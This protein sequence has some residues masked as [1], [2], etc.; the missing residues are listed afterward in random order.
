MEVLFYFMIGALCSLLVL[1]AIFCIFVFVYFYYKL[2]LWAFE[3][4]GI[5]NICDIL[6]CFRRQKG[7]RENE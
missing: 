5:E 6:D 7:E 1:F 4:L 3:K 2:A